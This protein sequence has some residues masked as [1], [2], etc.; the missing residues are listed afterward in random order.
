VFCDFFGSDCFACFQLW[1]IGEVWGWYW[2]GQG[3]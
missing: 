3:A 2:G 1:L